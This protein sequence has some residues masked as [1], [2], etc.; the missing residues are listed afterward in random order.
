MDTGVRFPNCRNM[1]PKKT[2]L[3][4]SLTASMHSSA[5]SEYQISCQQNHNNSSA[6][7]SSFY[8]Q[9]L[10]MLQISFRQRQDRCPINRTTKN[11]HVFYFRPPARTTRSR[12]LR[13]L[14]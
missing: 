11:G 3:S 2:V 14:R 6:T 8:G 9:N 4:S 13:T 5:L 7:E 10:H 1:Q 12:S